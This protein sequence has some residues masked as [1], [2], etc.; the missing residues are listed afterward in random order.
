MTLNQKT[1]LRVLH[2]RTLMVRLKTIHK[3]VALPI[4]S[5]NMILCVLASAGIAFFHIGTYI[6]E[7]VHGDLGRTLPNIGSLT[8][9]QADIFQLDVLKIY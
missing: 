7:F 5:C 6:K 8:N 4:D 1:P 2:R 9:N 3:L